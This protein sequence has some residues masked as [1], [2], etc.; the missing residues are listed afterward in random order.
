[1]ANPSFIF[2]FS[3][4][5]R[6][7]A[8]FAVKS[9]MLVNGL[10][11]PSWRVL[12]SGS[13]S[14]GVYAQLGDVIRTEAD[15]AREGAWWVVQGHGITEGFVVWRQQVLFQLNAAGQV[16]IAVS[17]RAGFV[18]GSPDADTA[19]SASDQTFV[20]GGGTS[21]SPTYETL[22]PSAGHWLDARFDGTSDDVWAIAY[23]TGGGAVTAVL[24]ILTTP[25]VRNSAGELVDKAPWVYVARAG[26]D[27]TLA[28]TLTSET[29]GPLGW[30]AY[31]VT[32]APVPGPAAAW[33]RLP[34]GAV[35]A[36]DA[37]DAYRPA[38]PDGVA[39][40]PDLTFVLYPSAPALALRRR[41]LSG[42]SLVAP[43]TG[44]ANTTGV[45]GYAVNALLSG[46]RATSPTLQVAAL[47][48]GAAT[49]TYCL[50]CGDLLLPWELGRE[51]A[52]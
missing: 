13:G 11:Q 44:N 15:C 1:M 48:T 26:S 27:C 51:V 10:G 12:T 3:V 29:R 28:A 9:M 36:L 14:G 18:Q 33:V 40:D 49:S 45:K 25:I 4:T 20:I 17:P 46:I 38:F 16:R 19:P 22:W 50:A 21:G 42:A 47:P 23:P 37:G 30:L 31:A 7:A 8:W 35:A 34:L 43:E 52:R 24:L 32:T 41:A 5:S 2:D 6:A 39:Q